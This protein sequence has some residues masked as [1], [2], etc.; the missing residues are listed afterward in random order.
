M[1]VC[2]AMWWSRLDSYLMFS[3]SLEYWCTDSLEGRFRHARCS[4]S[5]KG[6]WLCVFSAACFVDVDFDAKVFRWAYNYFIFADIHDH[7]YKAFY[8]THVGSFELLSW[9]IDHLLLCVLNFEARCMV[10]QTLL[11]QVCLCCVH[12]EYLSK[13]FD[14]FGYPSP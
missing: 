9:M 2:T 4:A 8:F 10:W 12:Q 11:Q 3:V 5:V 13:Y 1:L 7:L 6:M 14:I